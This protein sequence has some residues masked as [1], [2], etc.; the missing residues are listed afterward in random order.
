MHCLHYE[1]RTPLLST[2]VHDPT[3]D[4]DHADP[5]RPDS[6]NPTVPLGVPPTPTQFLHIQRNQSAD[7]AF[8]ALADA[9]ECVITKLFHRGN[10]MGENGGDVTGVSVPTR[11][12][13][14]A[15]LK[16]SQARAKER[17]ATHT[18]L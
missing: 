11:K 3:A 9:L 1:H 16:G 4:L 13:V 7:A 2:R 18:E 5:R 8:K 12:A 17:A 6:R 14:E 15:A 10:G